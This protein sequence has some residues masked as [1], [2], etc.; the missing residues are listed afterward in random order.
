MPPRH[1]KS[2]A[3][4]R[5]SMA[6]SKKKEL[7][8]ARV[9]P[10]LRVHSDTDS[11][12]E[13]YPAFGKKRNRLHTPVPRSSWQ[14]EALE[15]MRLGDVFRLRTVYERK[16]ANVNLATKEKAYGGFRYITWGPKSYGGEPDGE[17]MLHLAVRPDNGRYPNR[18][19]VVECLI[20]AGVD[21]NLRSGDDR[22]PRDLNTLL[23]DTV[24]PIKGWTVKDAHAFFLSAGKRVKVAH[25]TSW[26]KV[27]DA[28][29]VDGLAIMGMWSDQAF[30]TWVDERLADLTR[31]GITAVALEE[32]T[33]RWIFELERIY[34]EHKKAAKARRKREAK[35]AA[36]E[37]RKR[38]LEAMAKLKAVEKRLA[39]KGLSVAAFQLARDRDDGDSTDASEG[40][41]AARPDI[42]VARD[43][44]EDE[45]ALDDFGAGFLPPLDGPASRPNSR[46]AFRGDLSAFRGRVDGDPSGTP[47]GSRPQTSGSDDAAR[48]EIERTQ[49]QMSAY[50]VG[51]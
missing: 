1:R 2:E 29:R 4:T 42:E 33:P 9:N 27:F 26:L 50:A 28:Y 43:L 14:M 5:H 31:V 10:D 32:E 15:A 21:V 46:G 41:E 34:E 23:M 8:E 35:K 25:L 37:K 22:T 36:E 6:V 13:D 38:E 39:T 30:R 49:P 16:G 44:D 40:E 11:S 7:E 3:T 47:E 17:T 45:R 24:Y 19:E 18:H 20:E 48:R 51:R 12:E